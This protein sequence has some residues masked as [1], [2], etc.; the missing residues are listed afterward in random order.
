MSDKAQSD[1]VQL[2][3]HA[4]TTVLTCRSI[5]RYNT[6]L[7][8]EQKSDLLADIDT[9]VRFLRERLVANTAIE[10]NMVMPQL[11]QAGIPPA[12]TPQAN[13]S[14]EDDDTG[15]ERT[16]RAL[17]RIYHTYSGKQQGN[18]RVLTGRFNEVLAALNE[19]EGLL[20]KSQD[21]EPHHAYATGLLQGVGGFI[22][23]LY[24]LFMEFVRALAGALE[25]CNVYIDTEE[26]SSMHRHCPENKLP[27]NPGQ[28]P[29][30]VDVYRTHQQLNTAQG[31]ISGSIS[32]AAAFLIFLEEGLESDLDKRD[33]VV[34]QLHRIRQLLHDLANLLAS[35][36][37]AM[38]ILLGDQHMEG[39]DP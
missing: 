27:A 11:L 34:R 13:L 24:C 14:D 19:V 8:D 28:A 37:N 7:T 23:D 21:L 20:E 35:Y 26:I 29:T 30:L 36:E 2:F 17:Y 31:T 10:T 6:P 4:M 5:V 22:A 16:L 9:A 25:G 1:P 12:G 39:T 33:E 38:A 18:T 32:E 3:E 15:D